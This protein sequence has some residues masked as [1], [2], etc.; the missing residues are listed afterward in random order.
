VPIQNNFDFGA[1]P[2][3]DGFQY[4]VNLQPVLPFSLNEK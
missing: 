3:D 1:G 2:T 4:K